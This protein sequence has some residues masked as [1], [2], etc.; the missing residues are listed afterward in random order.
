MGGQFDV[1]EFLALGNGT[2]ILHHS[3]YSKEQEVGGMVGAQDFQQ[4]SSS[5]VVGFFVLSEITS[6]EVERYDGLRVVEYELTGKRGYLI[7]L[8]FKS[9]LPEVGHEFVF[10]GAFNLIV[11]QVVSGCAVVDGLAGCHEHYLFDGVGEEDDVRNGV[12]SLTAVFELSFLYLQCVDGR[13]GISRSKD[14]QCSVFHSGKLT[15]DSELIATMTTP[16]E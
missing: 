11:L 14:G 3:F 12:V 13:I 4:F 15:F 5:L 7:V 9:L 10:I 2:C 8:Q 1:F 16:Q 6:E